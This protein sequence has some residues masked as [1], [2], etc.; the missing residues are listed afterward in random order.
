M[1]ISQINSAS[2]ADGSVVATDI[3]PA[4]ITNA[5]L[6]NSS[7]TING[8]S[9]SLG[10]STSLASIQWQAVKTTD[11]NAVAGYGYFCNT[12]SNTIT[13]TLPASPTIGDT[14][15]LV[16]YARTF[17]TYNLTVGRNGNKIQ[18]IASNSVISTSG[19]S[20]YIVYMDSTNG[21]VYTNQS[22]VGLLGPLFITATGGTVLT[23]AVNGYK[24]H[25][26]TGDGCFVVSQ[27]GNGPTMASGGP[28][29]V[30]YLV[31][32]G[33][34]GA[35]SGAGAGGGGAGGYRTSF[36]SPSCAGSFPV[37]ILTYP[38]TV[39]A[40]GA[41][42]TGSPAYGVAGS[43]STFSTITSAG[44][45]RGSRGCAGQSS[46]GGNGGS[47]GGGG[48]G[49]APGSGPYDTPSSNPGGTGNTPP[50]S[51]SQGNNGGY[52]LIRFY[53]YQ[54]GGGGGGAGTAGT[55]G[56]YPNV[57]SMSG[58][59]TGSTILSTVFGPTAPSYGTTGPSPTGRYF[60]GGGGGSGSLPG[61]SPGGSGG[62][63]PGGSG[64]TGGTSNT[65][66]GG[67]AC[68]QAGGKGIVVIRYKYQ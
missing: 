53:H 35:G 19:A 66:G 63:G 37:S 40:G 56:D 11:F 45:G 30:D 1:P 26:F 46:A 5:K 62:G 58:G 12:T 36:P 47:G 41:G 61:A 17:A 29:N 65:G 6:V 39:G 49:P 21:W 43:P 14:I 4:T 13:V 20:L 15:A 64:A 59:G 23:D 38:V 9:V 25:V 57:P 33:A 34:G 28:V 60:A 54:G 8:Q 52:G 10:S 31:V 3:A 44:G 67:G 32:A 18:G 68:G 50:V 51:P 42:A 16:D 27:L 55:P 48:S 22:N 24:T 2:I 7:V